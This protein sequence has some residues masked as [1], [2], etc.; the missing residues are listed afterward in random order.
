MLAYLGERGES[1]DAH[2]S[3][4]NMDIAQ[5]CRRLQADQELRW[6]VMDGILECAEQIGAA[7]DHCGL[8]SMFPQ[9]RLGCLQR[10]RGH[11]LEW[12]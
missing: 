4:L 5:I 2:S 6:R 12:L 10:I 7:C 9:Q 8:L 11:V 1:A 3:G